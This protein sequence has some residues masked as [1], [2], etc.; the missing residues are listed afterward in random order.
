MLVA[1]FQLSHYSNDFP[2]IYS[3]LN[4]CL[5]MAQNNGQAE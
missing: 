4:S 1:M 2:L 5:Y 3:V